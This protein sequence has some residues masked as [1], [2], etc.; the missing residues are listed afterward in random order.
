[1]G[2]AVSFIM[3]R[4]ITITIEDFVHDQ[5][6]SKGINMSAVCEEAL[7]EVI[8][9]FDKTLDPETCKHHWTFPFSIP[10]G[11]AKECK[12]CGTIKKVIIKK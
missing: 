8:G 11:L 9:S 3:K 6:K 1:M 12:R 10:F 7:R 2:L 4:H 5:V